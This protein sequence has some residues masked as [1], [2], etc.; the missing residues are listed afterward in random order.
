[1]RLFVAA[2]VGDDTRAQVRSVREQLEPLLRGR[3]APRVAWV[4]EQAAHVTLRFIGEIA[5]EHAVLVESALT[6][7]LALA[8]FEVGWDRLGSFPRGRSPRVIWIGAT[9]GRDALSALATMVAARLEAIVGP[10][11]ARPF[12]P[13]LTIA[14]VRD[15]GR[16]AWP[17]L[18]THVSL[19][20]IVARIDHVTLYRSRLSP[21]GATYTEV[22]RAALTTSEKLT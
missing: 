16:V 1:M 20:P 22:C 7:T 19:E 5:D 21:K 17:D 8:P 9:R 15:P 4:R 10:G 14:R 11:E 12:N 13:H 3:R 6:P 18:L 2:D